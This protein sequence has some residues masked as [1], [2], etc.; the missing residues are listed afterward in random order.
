MSLAC[1]CWCG[2]SVLDLI[3]GIVNGSSLSPQSF[4]SYC[5]ACVMPS[6]SITVMSFSVILT[7]FAQTEVD[8]RSWLVI[9]AI[10]YQLLIF[11]ACP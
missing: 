10:F 2:D 5:L 4:V 7:V 3:D 11:C 6:V 8:D 1:L 9:P